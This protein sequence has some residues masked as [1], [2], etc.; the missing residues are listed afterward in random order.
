MD[1]NNKLEVDVL[2]ICKEQFLSLPQ[3]VLKHL[4]LSSILE[5]FN[6]DLRSI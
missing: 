6:L 5:A 3:G 4:F 1:T 2:T